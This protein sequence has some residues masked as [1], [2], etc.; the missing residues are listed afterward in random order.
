MLGRGGRGRVAAG[1]V[2]VLL[3]T[4]LG[5]AAAL[6]VP[7][8]MAILGTRCVVIAASYGPDRVSW[9]L[10]TMLG[11]DVP[12]SAPLRPQ[13]IEPD[14]PILVVTAVANPFTTYLAEILRAE[15]LNE[16]STLDRSLLTPAALDGREVVVVGEMPLDPAG[17]A[18][19]SAW[20]EA[21]GTLIAMHPDRRLAP[22]LGLTPTDGTLSDGYL[23]VDTNESFGR[24]IVGETM[25]FHGGAGLWTL[26]SAEHGTLGGDTTVVATLYADADTATRFPAVTKH[27][28][29]SRG[30]VAVAFAYDLARSVVYT[31]QGNP[32]WAGANRHG[33]PRRS[34]DLFFGGAP[35]DAARDWVDFRKLAIPQADEQQRLLAN[36]ILQRRPLPRFWYLPKGLNA[37]VVMTGDDHGDAGMRPRF[38]RYRDASPA[39]CSV[40]DWECVRATGYLY[41]GTAFTPADAERYTR[42]GFEVALHA[43]TKCRDWSPTSLAFVVGLQLRQFAAAYPGVPSPATSRTHCAAWSD[44]STQPEIEAAHGIRLDANY[45][46]YPESWAA[47][48]AGL[49]TGSGFPLRFAARDGSVIDCYQA[50]T[51]ITDESGMALPAVC[52]A[53]LDRANGPEGF[54]GVVTANMH[55]DWVDHPGS[56][57]IVASARAHAVPVISARQLLEWL[58]GRNAS[59]FRAVTRADGTLGFTVAVGTGARNLRGMVPTRSTAGSL[60]GISREGVAVAHSVRSIKGIEYAFF[61][62]DSGSYVVRYARAATQ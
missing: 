50:A 14:G 21:G 26:G 19:L 23:R 5:M 8:R 38:D 25:Q 51:Q 62:A 4:A 60:S 42:L 59:S 41:V 35:G 40:D 30:G 10:A 9:L 58:D 36:V 48:R 27:V 28:V 49:F 39:G 24:G 57:A 31:R 1:T 22:L 12:R 13:T 37:A 33:R 43:D 6:G 29:G 7:A 20:T 3:A 34:V 16:F 52:D 53:L 44:W 54:Y 55:F 11:V 18:M 46:F 61:A 17:V 2:A 45:Y 56:D 15:G 32:A 47:G